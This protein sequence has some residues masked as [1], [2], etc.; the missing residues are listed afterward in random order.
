MAGVDA[1]RRIFGRILQV[2][3]WLGAA[4]IGGVGGCKS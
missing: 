1:M 4:W 3:G 2:I